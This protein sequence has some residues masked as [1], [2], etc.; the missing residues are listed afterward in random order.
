MTSKE[1]EPGSGLHAF[2]LRVVRS[3]T[4]AGL[5]VSY[6][7]LGTGDAI[8]FTCRVPYGPTHGFTVYDVNEATCRTENGSPMCA[9]DISYRLRQATRLR[10]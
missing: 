3:R 6:F 4:L 10:R 9:S 1:E 5:E 7:P 2:A 8:H